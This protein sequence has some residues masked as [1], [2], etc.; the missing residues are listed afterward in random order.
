MGVAVV[1]MEQ[2]D[3]L[4][5]EERPK[6]TGQTGTTIPQSGDFAPVSLLS[7]ALRLFIA[8][9]H[10]QGRVNYLVSVA[11]VASASFSL[12]FVKYIRDKQSLASPEN[13]PYH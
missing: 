6:F 3:M 13:M 2:L 7:G 1:V 4:G 8:S 5:I 12:L 11:E 9:L 10:L